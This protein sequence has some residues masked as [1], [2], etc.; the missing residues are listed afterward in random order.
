MQYLYK[1]NSSYIYKR[2]IPNHP[3]F[4]SFTLNL[5]C[6]NN[7]KFV[8]IFNKLTKDFFD[9]LKLEKVMYQYNDIINILDNYKNEALQE[10]TR[11]KDNKKNYEELRHEHLRKLFPIK[12]IDPIQGEITLSGADKK[13]LKTAL[14]S[15]KNLSIGSYTQT[16]PHLKQIGKDIVS[17]GTDDLKKLYVYKRNST[18]EQE[19]LDF[20]SLLL[21]TEAE[22]IKE[23]KRRVE[24]RFE[25]AKDSPKT[26]E[27]EENTNF[28]DEQKKEA[29]T[30]RE[31]EEDYL[32]NFCNKTAELKDSK[33]EGY[34][35]QKITNI[36]TEYL[37]DHKQYLASSVNLKACTDILNNIIPRIPMKVGNIQG[38]YSFYQVYKNSKGLKDN[39]YRR[40]STIGQDLRRFK[41]YIDFLANRGFLSEKDKLELTQIKI[42]KKKAL[43]KE[44]KQ[45]I[46]PEEK[47]RVAFKDSMLQDFFNINIHNEYSIILNRFN[48]N[49]KMNLNN[50]IAR[51]YTQL[52]LFFTGTR[53]KEILLAKTND[54]EIVTNENEEEEL[55]IY[56]E[57]NEKR[58]VKTDMSRRVI[59]IHS[60]LS[61]NLNFINFIKKAKAENREYLFNISP[62]EATNIFKQF[63]RNNK[64]IISKH[65]SRE[66]DFYN[67]QYSIYSFRHKFKTHLLNI[68]I[69]AEIVNKYQGHTITNDDKGSSEIV[70]GYL[71]MD[72]EMIENI[73]KFEKHLTI[74]E[75]WSDLIEYSNKIS[76]L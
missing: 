35:M 70:M 64:S 75:D 73:E 23:D 46:I 27:N 49:H 19:F 65:L 38:A 37:E 74:K 56:I 43:R 51:F 58:S 41:N 34:K 68:G 5:T 24:N 29:I 59:Y 33:L 1:K 15:F 76:K 10:Y 52:I 22:I 54:C 57:E 13:V 71:T 62:N 39:K 17:R 32:N 26:N 55:F 31:I 12:K 63:N 2:R 66:D 30:I 20:L 9:Y 53:P 61:H 44:A 45:K 48:K 47:T 72:K 16:K 4:Y 40:K 11:L 7:Q 21:K 50:F 6:K 42:T 14:E 3:F 25:S 18:K 60:F 28:I 67:T 36:L 8:I 69:N